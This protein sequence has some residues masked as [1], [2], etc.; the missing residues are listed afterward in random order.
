MKIETTQKPAA[1]IEA[2]AIAVFLWKDEPLTGSA[3]EIDTATEG[4][5]L[6]HI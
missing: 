6:I 2:S 5:S 3:L 4:L 1:D